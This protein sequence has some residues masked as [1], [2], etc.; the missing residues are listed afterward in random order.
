MC[1]Y[2]SVSIY[3]FIHTCISCM[4]MIK[5]NEMRGHEF[6]REKA[7]VYGRAWRKKSKG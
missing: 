3:S 1:I 6:E 5:I 7:E 2:V 4:Y